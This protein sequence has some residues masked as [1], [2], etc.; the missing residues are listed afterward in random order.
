LAEN[1][2]HFQKKRQSFTPGA[3]S[4]DSKQRLKPK[5]N[6]EEWPLRLNDSLI[7]S[8]IRFS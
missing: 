6:P 4:L 7:A 2:A 5:T 3:S 1:L 8:T